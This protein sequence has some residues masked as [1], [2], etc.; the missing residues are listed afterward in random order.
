MD[1]DEAQP[2]LLR[3]FIQMSPWR[4]WLARPTV[5]REVD[6]SILSGDACFFFRLFKS[7]FG[8]CVCVREKTYFAFC[9][10]W[11][12]WGD[13]WRGLVIGILPCEG[14]D[15]SE[16]CMWI[17]T[18]IF[19]FYKLRDAMIGMC[20]H[21]FTLT[22]ILGS[23]SNSHRLSSPLPHTSKPSLRFTCTRAPF[24]LEHVNPNPSTH[25]SS[26]PTALTSAS[27]CSILTTTYDTSFSANRC[28][29]QMRGPPLNGRY[30]HPGFRS[31]L[32]SHR[33][34]RN[35]AASAP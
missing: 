2:H 4:N 22:V 8:V 11:G 3:H 32:V 14:M 28:P 19:H 29:R 17:V 16:Q 26:I 20:A 7:F 34:G 1:R 35:S 25:A 13:L 18:R 10:K 33:S 15:C 21:D 31:L 9:G 30:A 12:E 6:S 23:H 5:N 24:R 27:S